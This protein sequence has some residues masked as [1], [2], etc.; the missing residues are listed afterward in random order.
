M[1]SQEIGAIKKEAFI[2]RISKLGG[3]LILVFTCF[4]S[5]LSITLDL[6][7]EKAIGKVSNAA[8]DCSRD[9][10]CWTGRVDFTTKE[11]EDITFS[12]WTNSYL[13]DLDPILSGRS[14]EDYG[15]YQV[16]YFES[17]PKLAK[18]KLA[19]ALEYTNHL[20]WFCG[21]TLLLLIGLAFSSQKSRNK[22]LVIDL[23]S[24]RKKQ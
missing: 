8:K 10:T 23:S 20:S 21:G 2:S 5:I 14:Y 6:T 4:A 16:R 12:P 24:F 9:G 13:F 19:F 17:F 1:E 22:P 11:G 15:K 7:G 18:V 3:I